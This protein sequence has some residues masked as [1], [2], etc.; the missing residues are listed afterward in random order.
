MD[1]RTAKNTEQKIGIK[2]SQDYLV[3]GIYGL[4]F[5]HLFVGLVR[6]GERA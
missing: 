3:G 4:V 6:D 1:D 2:S 5:G